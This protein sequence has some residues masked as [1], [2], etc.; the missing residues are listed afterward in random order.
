MNAAEK[1]TSSQAMIDLELAQKLHRL[2][3]WMG[4]SQ[5]VK[6]KWSER[7]P[8]VFAASISLAIFISSLDIPYQDL[9]L[10]LGVILIIG[11]CALISNREDDDS[12]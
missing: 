8:A 5:V 11:I 9:A 7:Q 1:I 2:N 4:I 3:G 6:G 12:S 10:I